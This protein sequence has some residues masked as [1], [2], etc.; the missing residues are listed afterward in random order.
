[1][2]KV[3]SIGNKQQQGQAVVLPS[4]AYSVWKKASIAPDELTLW[5]GGVTL[6][7]GQKKIHGP[8]TFGA[9]S[10]KTRSASF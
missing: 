8:S 6:N 3:I 9:G 1:M 5:G 2:P 7:S 10:S 4:L